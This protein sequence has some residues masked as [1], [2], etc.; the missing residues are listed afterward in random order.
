VVKAEGVT[1]AIVINTNLPANE[2]ARILMCDPEFA[3]EAAQIL[4]TKQTK[5]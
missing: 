4:K 3:F 5:G 1:P 2:W